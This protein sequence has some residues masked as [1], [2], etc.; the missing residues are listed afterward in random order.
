MR[1]VYLFYG[2]NLF[3]ADWVFGSSRCFFRTLSVLVN[4]RLHE[5]ILGTRTVWSTD[6]HG[7]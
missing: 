7:T 6:E 2:E 3:F 5:S 4:G 1:K